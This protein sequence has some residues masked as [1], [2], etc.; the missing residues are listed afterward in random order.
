MRN[1]GVYKL[2]YIL[3]LSYL[4]AIDEPL[5]S[6]TYGKFTCLFSMGQSIMIV[7]CTML[8][9]SIV[10]DYHLTR[11]SNKNN[12]TYDYRDDLEDSYERT[13]DF[14]QLFTIHTEGCIIPSESFLQPI[15]NSERYSINIRHCKN[16]QYPLLGS[17]DTNIWVI[18]KHLEWYTMP[19]NAIIRCCYKGLKT[20]RSSLI[21]NGKVEYKGC[22]NFNDTIVVNDEYARVTCSYKKII[23]YNQ[24]FAFPIKKKSSR[25]K[26]YPFE[27]FEDIP[28]NI[29]I[30]GLSSMSR[31]KFHKTMSATAELLKVKGAIEFKGYNTAT[32][33]PHIT[34]LIPVLM[35][36]SLSELKK[37]CWPNHLSTLDKCPL[38]WDRF[39]DAGYFTALL[40]DTAKLSIL[41]INHFKFPGFSYSPTDYY[42]YPFLQEVESSKI[43]N[44][45]CLGSKFAFQLMLDYLVDLT[46]TLKS[47]KLFGI[48]WESSVT[49]KDQ[50]NLM[51][52]DNS[53]KAMIKKL[54]DSGYLNKTVLIVLSDHGAVYENVTKTKQDL[55]GLEERLP[56]LYILPPPSFSRDY[57]SAFENLK[58]NKDRLT[59]PFD[60]HDTLIDLLDVNAINNEELAIRSKTSRSRSYS[61]FLEI[62][63]NRTCKSANIAH[64]L[65][66]C[67]NTMSTK[68]SNIEAQQASKQ[69]VKHING[70]ISSYSACAKLN[71]EKIVQVVELSQVYDNKKER[72]WRDFLVV[73]RTTPGGN[74][75]E[76]TMRR[77]NKSIW[78][79]TGVI[80]NS[81]TNVEH[82]DCIKDNELKMYCYCL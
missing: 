70:L 63:S 52:L 14:E 76:A 54:D 77:S 58:E 51:L 69:L 3:E 78:S 30:M 36:L 6:I 62:P 19:K 27:N 33:Y 80:K 57:S 11:K 24:Y 66:S 73:V 75:F 35:G 43:G 15:K 21:I 81:N 1:F 47:F 23:L 7:C 2:N 79:P 40:E 17:N 64:Q 10:G 67:F 45:Y 5:I 72:A 32:N 9:A 50:N 59:T 60:L 22:I 29:L 71:L 65:C 68:E 34:N 26:E 28:Y 8:A 20:T 49:Y 44:P 16:S 25:R 53:Y 56:I 46:T 61:L 37:T 38:I 48:F 74:V 13:N 55:K 39:K 42:L 18:T 4:K 12:F 82:S 31:L 41:N